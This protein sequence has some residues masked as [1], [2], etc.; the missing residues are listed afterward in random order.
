MVQW[1][2]YSVF[3]NLIMDHQYI[4]VVEICKTNMQPYSSMFRQASLHT[5]WCLGSANVH[6]QLCCV[7]NINVNSKI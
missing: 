3:Y 1:Y 6:V 7:K 2:N 4:T 5:Q